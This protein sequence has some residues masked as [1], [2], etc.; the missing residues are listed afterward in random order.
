MRTA[1]AKQTNLEKYG[2]EN[3][4]QVEIFKE[5]AKETKLEKYGDA[6]YNN[7]KK[8]FKTIENNN[9]NIHAM[10]TI[11]IGKRCLKP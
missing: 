3:P 8:M 2:V 7:R 11:I 6:N 10:L 5:K 9:F 1:K 4:F